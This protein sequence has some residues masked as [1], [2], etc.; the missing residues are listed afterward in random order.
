MPALNVLDAL[1]GRVNLNPTMNPGGQVEAAALAFDPLNLVGGPLGKLA[2]TG[3]QALPEASTGARALGRLAAVDDAYKAFADLPFEGARHLM[4]RA[5]DARR[6]KQLAEELTSAPPLPTPEN[7]VYGREVYKS[8]PKERIG[9]PKPGKAGISA[10]DVARLRGFSLP[11]V[12]TP[13][14]AVPVPPA[15]HGPRGR[16]GGDRRREDGDLRSGA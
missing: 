4:G 3:A 8:G 6:A 2:R 9:T 16:P 10:A 5:R 15:R 7:T 13:D 11:G 1:P 14:P 12:G